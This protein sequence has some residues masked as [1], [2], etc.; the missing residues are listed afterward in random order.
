MILF[1]KATRCLKF[2]NI[3]WSLRFKT[4]L[5]NN[6]LHFKTGYQ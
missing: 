4:P 5:F 1:T 6:Y 3:Q 2:C